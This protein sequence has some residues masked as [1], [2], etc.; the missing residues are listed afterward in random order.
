[1]AKIKSDFWKTDWFLGLVIALMFI[2]FFRN[3]DLIQSLE[4]KAYDGAVKMSSKNPNDKIAIIAIDDQSISNIG[5][6]PWSREIHADMIDKL[7][8]AKAKVV[9]NTVFFFEPQQDP[10]FVYVNKLME[11]HRKAAAAAQAS[12]ALTATDPAAPAPA[13][14]PPEFA[15]M[16]KLLKEAELALNTDRRLAESI[17]KAGNVVIPVFLELGAPRGKPDKPLPEFALK[18]SLEDKNGSGIEARGVQVPIE[19]LG[20][21]ATSVGHLNSSPE[22]DGG[23]RTEPLMIQFFDRYFPSFALAVAAKSL[24]LNVTDIKVKWG[25]RVTLG[26]LGISVDEGNSMRTYFYKDRDGKPAF[27]IDSFFDVKSGKIPASKYTDKIVL[28]GAT[29][30]GVGSAFPT[31]VSPAMT[32]VESMAHTVSSILSEHFFVEPGWGWLLS[33]LVVLLVAAYLIALLPKL[34]AKAGAAMTLGLLAGL[35]I[36]H[37]ASM[38][39]GGMWFQLM[40]AAT[41]L[42]VGHVLLV[43]KRFIMT[44]AGKQ[45]SDAESAESNR[46]LGLAFQGQ[47]QLDMSFDKFR[48]VPFD[49]QLM[50][51]LYNLALDF[52]RK[53]Q[54]NKAQSVYDHMSSHNPKFKDL[55]LKRERA[56]TMSETVILGG[57]GG[58]ANASMNILDGA[59]EKPMLGRYQVEKELGKG[60][61]GVVYLGKDPKI[62]RVVAI[63]TMALSQEFDADEIE[64]VKQRFFR[65]AETA[66][67]LN[68]P[69]IVTIF[70]AGE[71]HDLA[72]IAMEFLKGKDLVPYTKPDNLLSMERAVSITV[73]VAE[74]LGYAHR[75]NVVHRDIKPANI[76]YEYESDTVKVTDF[77]IA[78]ITDSS[79]TKTGM[80]LGTPSYMSPEQ[81]SGK[82]VDGR[83]DLFS[84]AVSLYQMLTGQLPFVGDS[85]AQLMF[86]IANDKEVDIRTLNPNVPDGLAQVLHAAMLKDADQRFQTGDELAAALRTF[87]GAELASPSATGIRSAG[88]T[89]APRP[90]TVALP[91]APAPASAAVNPHAGGTVVMSATVAATTQPL[92]P[93]N[94]PPS[95]SAAPTAPSTTTAGGTVI[96]SAVQL[97]QLAQAAQAT[98]AGGTLIMSAAQAAQM[99]QGAQ[100]VHAAQASSPV[101]APKAVGGAAAAAPPAAK[102]PPDVDIAL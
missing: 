18:A 7:T 27:Q 52:E 30:A 11:L 44:E 21:A 81:L 1:M 45:K 10:G 80:V 70:D 55:E 3:S 62:G 99:V 35:I 24:N 43:T 51:N 4:R 56:K 84:L 94:L 66:G 69:N 28:I 65:E 49:D 50:D 100:V 87:A 37:F 8:A 53:R 83:S 40:G 60:A 9:G 59:V 72:F 78:R 33:L 82:K 13:G 17:T 91:V 63:K 38:V 22:V 54:F 86:K 31:P 101:S 14:L 42:V 25:E 15:D 5:R 73:R 85:M 26:K 47:G 95:T 90:P 98:T 58:R 12:P 23:V 102:P 34:K 61:M 6:W 71:E 36:A 57:G 76:M 2:L 41:L 79:K 93:L 92:A 96:M 19:M 20:K 32:P 29:A 64:D 68:H 67:R 97:A 16:G 48:K 77:G 75:L 89:P 46:M 74:A 39:G 88:S